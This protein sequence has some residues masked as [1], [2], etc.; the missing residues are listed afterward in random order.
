[1]DIKHIEGKNKGKIMLYA[2]STCVWCKKTK[3]LLNNLGVDYY[4]I[5][6]D[7]LEEEEKEK[8][9]KEIMRFNPSCSFPTTVINNEKCIVGYKEQEIKEALGE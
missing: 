9:K 5:D 8:A 3:K 1:M 6:V 7:L 4:Y 2:L